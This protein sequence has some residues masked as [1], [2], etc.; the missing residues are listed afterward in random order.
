MFTSLGLDTLVID[1]SPDAFQPLSIGGAPPRDGYALEGWVSSARF[2]YTVIYKN[3]TLIRKQFVAYRD[4]YLLK[5]F[6]SPLHLWCIIR[7]WG[8]CLSGFLK[9]DVS[10]FLNAD[11]IAK[12]GSANL[13]MSTALLNYSS[14]YSNAISLLNDPQNYDIKQVITTNLYNIWSSETNSHGFESEIVYLFDWCLS[15]IFHRPSGRIS[16]VIFLNRHSAVKVGVLLL[17]IFDSLLLFASLFALPTIRGIFL[18][19]PAFGRAVTVLMVQ[20]SRTNLP[21][22]QSS[23]R[24]RGKE[25]FNGAFKL[26]IPVSLTELVMF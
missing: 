10:S 22:S 4:M 24:D 12:D 25:L 5:C 6:L 3:R 14:A 21:Q 1:G 16:A 7:R 2:Y 26:K 8:W 23:I 20:L 19:S 17:T 9:K 18:G 13:D 15:D 11:G